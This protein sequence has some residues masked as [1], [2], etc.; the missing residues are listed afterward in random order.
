VV[1]VEDLAPWF[2]GAIGELHGTLSAQDVSIAGPSG[3]VIANDFFSEE[4][5]EITMFLP[6]DGSF[7]AVG[8]VQALRLPR[9][10]LATLVHVGPHDDID[11][12]YGAL[13]TYVSERAL[14]VDGPLRER[15]LVGLH[16]TQD[17][18]R[19]RTEIGWPIFRTDTESLQ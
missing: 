7:R 11:R 6:A 13:A 5:G 19:W 16:D 18:S 10:E 15:Y 12:A 9:V 2:E 17:Q 8:R 1:T 4:C 3:A 14:G